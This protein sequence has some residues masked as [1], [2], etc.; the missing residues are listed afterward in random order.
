MNDQSNQQSDHQGI[1]KWF[2]YNPTASNLLM[3]VFVI[4]GIVA[5]FTMRQEVFP[6]MLVDTIKI[7]AVYRGAT[8]SEVES[9]VVQPMEQSINTLLDI[10]TVVSEVSAGGANIFVMLEGNASVQRTM[11]EIRSAIASISSLP[12][13]LEPPIISQVRD[14]GGEVEFGFY[15]F[16]DRT[17][18]FEFAQDVRTRLLSLNP[19]GQVELEGVGEPEVTVRVSPDRMRLFGVSLSDVANSIGRATFELSGGA[20]R[21]S[22]GEYGLATGSD[23][24]FAGEFRDIAVV[25]SSTGAPL[26]LGQVADIDDGFSPEGARFRINGEL[27]FY[28][29]VYGSGPSTPQ[30]IS[31]S[32][33]AEIAEIESEMMKGGAV[34][35]DD[36]AKNYADR[37]GI[38]ADSAMIGLA[39]VLILLFL[40]LETRVALW[41]AIGLPVA[42]LGGV[43]LFATTPYTINF[44]S[45]FAF[46]IVI[47]VVVDDAVVIGESIFAGI[48]RGMTPIEAAADTVDRFSGAITLAIITNIIAFVP[49]LFLPGELGLFLLAIPIVTTCVFIIS[50]I[51]ALWILPGHLAH[52]KLGGMTG[53]HQRI[54]QESFERFRDLMVMPLVRSAIRNRGLVICVGL[55]AT[56]AVFSWV[57]S[58]RVA[59]ALQP[60]FESQEVHAIF[61]LNP[62]ASERQMDDIAAR[63]ESLGYEALQELGTREH[64][65]GSRMELAAP[66]SHNG[67]VTFTLVET[68]NRPFSSADFANLWQDKIGHPAELT[69]LA[70]DYVNGPGGGR[71]LTVELAHA[72][73]LISQMA[74]EDLVRELKEISGVEQISYRGNAFRSE[75]RFELTATG[76]ALGFDESEISSQIR[77][78]LDGLEAT[79]LTRGVNE[80]RVMIRGDHAQTM[81]ELRSL[82]LIAANGQQA[83][84]S[85]VATIQWQRGAVNIR[86]IN[87]QRVERVEA[88]INTEFV[89]KSLVEG[90][91]KDSILPELETKYEGLVTW[92]EA[93]DT[94]EDSETAQSVL[95]ATIGMLVAIFILISAYAR[96]ARRG[97]ILLSA[98][99]ICASGAFVGHLI[100]G[101]DLSAASFMGVL[102]LGGLVINAC[103]L[104]HLRYMECRSDNLSPEE[105]MLN[106]VRDRFRPIVLSSVTTLVGLAPLIFSNSIH[107]APLQ[108]VAISLGFG[109]LFSIPVI[110]ILLPC[111]VVVLDDQPEKVEEDEFGFKGFSYG[112]Q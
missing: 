65:E 47:G 5:I 17:E 50:L 90:L 16:N 29:T 98:L 94:N 10:K 36:D 24:R 111:F 77:A 27:G 96:S 56:A 46:V 92:D 2:L 85:D 102:A 28:L 21:S 34:I 57:S 15:G 49:I 7:E 52:S 44:I 48:Q 78:Q 33:R 91:I 68:E 23:R 112:R 20:F 63:M 37:A 107:A 40:V 70:M 22:T 35:F 97:G 31:A 4:S 61:S 95:L 99:P 88:S 106:A 66:S 26:T 53:R 45:I 12:V 11:D 73:P 30:E 110:L 13:D 41:V 93:I 18:M 108:P 55:S 51:E 62:G 84:L 6:T 42:M 60:Q 64:L 71:D 14:G 101:V 79:R 109:M 39:L 81:P 100:L 67:R 8:A 75:V 80:V 58:G 105:A 76:R 38:L 54:V 82:V 83:A 89:P 104:L 87:N 74:A 3:L 19:I 103:L 69:Q 1:A 25:E 86:R 72:N 32:V 43:A 9:Q 59:I